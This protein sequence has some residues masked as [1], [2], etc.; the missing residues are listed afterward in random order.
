[1]YI[2]GQFTSRFGQ[3]LE[4]YIGPNILH[5]LFVKELQNVS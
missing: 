1:M 4:Y 3:F 2:L 5:R